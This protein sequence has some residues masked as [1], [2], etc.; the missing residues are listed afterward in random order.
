[1][2]ASHLRKAAN[3]SKKECLEIQMMAEEEVV[4]LRQQ[5]I[6]LRQALRES[7]Q[8]CQLVQKEL[9]KEV[10][11]DITDQPAISNYN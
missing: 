1:M 3:H 6:A 2:Q 7:Q 5:L 8:E 11:Y 4:L 10:R 9:D